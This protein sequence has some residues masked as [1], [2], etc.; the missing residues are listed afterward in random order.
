MTFEQLWSQ[1]SENTDLGL[2]RRFVDAGGDVAR[3][4]ET[5]GWTLLH[6]ACEHGDLA[7]I[8]ALVECGADPNAADRDGT[9]VLHFAVDTDIDCTWQRHHSL[10]S[11]EFEI[12]KVLLELGA[13]PDLPDAVGRI[14]EDI[15]DGYDSKASAAFRKLYP[16]SGDLNA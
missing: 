5:L 14:A 3:F 7:L 13:K 4:D 8:R 1:I 6:L 16:D 11:L 9:P 12:T 2:L 10:D 15:A